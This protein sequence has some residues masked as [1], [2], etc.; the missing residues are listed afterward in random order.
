MSERI[1]YVDMHRAEPE[2]A[3]LFLRAVLAAGVQPVAQADDCLA[4][5]FT[6][7]GVEVPLV[8]M[9]KGLADDYGKRV[10]EAARLKA[11][12]YLETEVAQELER[13]RTVCRRAEIS[14]LEGFK[15]PAEEE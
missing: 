8:P 5:L 15:L 14:L 11:R 10:D 13:I 3:T 1:R 7:N 4:V 12:E 6:V 9:L 2:A